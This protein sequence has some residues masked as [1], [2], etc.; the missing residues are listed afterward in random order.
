MNRKKV[1][2]LDFPENNID[3]GESETDPHWLQKYCLAWKFLAVTLPYCVKV[4]IIP[5]FLEAVR[6]R[7]RQQRVS[8]PQ[9]KV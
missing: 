1:Y 8:R 5:A 6:S 3:V 2:P 9:H 7:S 4:P